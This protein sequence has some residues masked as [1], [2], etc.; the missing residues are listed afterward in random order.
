LP[1][2]G[3]AIAAVF[4]TVAITAIDSIAIRPMITSVVVVLVTIE[5]STS[6]IVIIGLHRSFLNRYSLEF[7][8]T[9]LWK[10]Y[11]IYMYLVPLLEHFQ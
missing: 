3:A 1:G 7:L 11:K 10:I 9:N 6:R 4:T 5:I 2:G 8:L